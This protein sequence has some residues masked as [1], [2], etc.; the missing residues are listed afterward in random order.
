[1]P[2]TFSALDDASVSFLTASSSAF[3]AAGILA[4]YSSSIPDSLTSSP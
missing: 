4:D 3:T 2:A 1:M